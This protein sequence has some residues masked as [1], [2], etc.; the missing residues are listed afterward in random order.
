MNNIEYLSCTKKFGLPAYVFD[1]GN[2]LLNN[3]EYAFL[4]KEYDVTP[5]KTDHTL[6]LLDGLEVHIK[7]Q[8]HGNKICNISRVCEEADGIFLTTQQCGGI[9]TADCTPVLIFS[10]N[11]KHACAIHCGWR[12]TYKKIIKNALTFFYNNAIDS[13]DLLCII[14]PAAQKCCYEVQDE[15]YNTT[16]KILE[17]YNNH[18]TFDCIYKKTIIGEQSKTSYYVSIP[19]IVHSQLLH[20]GVNNNNIFRAKDCTICDK[21]FFSHRRD[22]NRAGRQLSIIKV[23]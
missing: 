18:S 20:Y 6:R 1:S 7:K 15:F 14:G 17:E 13:K 4:G 16:E 5:F 12:S 19:E 9:I 23:L 3:F 8:V 2:A 22:Q 10:L 11:S 21:R